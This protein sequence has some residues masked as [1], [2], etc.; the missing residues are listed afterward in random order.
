LKND[1]KTNR[2]IGSILSIPGDY[3]PFLLFVHQIT[4]IFIE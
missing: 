1:K 2:I 3:Y 4:L